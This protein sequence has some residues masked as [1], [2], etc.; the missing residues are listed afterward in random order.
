MKDMYNEI[1]NLRGTTVNLYGHPTTISPEIEALQIDTL[2]IIKVLEDYQVTDFTLEETCD[3]CDGEGC[4]MCGNTGYIEVECKNVSDYIDYL[5]WLYGLEEIH[6][7][8]SYNWLAPVSNDFNFYM[9]RVEGVCF[10]EFKVHRFGDPRGN[11]T[12]PVLLKFDHENDFFEAIRETTKYVN[13]EVDGEDYEICI[14]PF[15]DRLEVYKADGD[16]KG[17][18]YST[19]IEEAREEIKG[20]Y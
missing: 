5:G 17:T 14:I 4:E 11:Y 8:N 6:S 18:I 10:V 20:L 9:Y 13:V 16:Y 1:K 12:E 19:D 2:D 7:D 3:D 15:S